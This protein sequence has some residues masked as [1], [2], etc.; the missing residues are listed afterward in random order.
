MAKEP[1]NTPYENALPTN[2]DIHISITGHDVDDDFNPTPVE[3]TF[4]ANTTAIVYT[5]N[6]D[7]RRVSFAILGGISDSI[8]YDLL[9]QFHEVAPEQL[10]K[11]ITSYLVLQTLKYKLD[12]ETNDE[13]EK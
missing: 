10:R 2:I 5:L 13:E 3:A 4:D 7:T 1:V 6:G 11:A 12:D 8:L 9:K